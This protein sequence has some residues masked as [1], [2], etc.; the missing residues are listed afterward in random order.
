MSRLGLG[1]RKEDSSDESRIV[2]QE[3]QAVDDVERRGLLSGQPAKES[4]RRKFTVDKVNEWIGTGVERTRGR[5][6]FIAAFFAILLLGGTL[7]R[8]LLLS[9]QASCNS[10]PNMQ[11]TGTKLR[12]NGTHDYKRTVVIVSIDGLR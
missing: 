11:F 7:S 10:H 5:L 6:S 3:M 9:P 12:S 8:H 1:E 4:D 2:D